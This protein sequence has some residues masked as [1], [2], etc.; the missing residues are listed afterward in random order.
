MTVPRGPLWDVPLF[1]LPINGLAT[2]EKIT[3]ANGHTVDYPFTGHWSV[4]VRGRNLGRR[5][6]L[7]TAQKAFLHQTGYRFRDYALLS[8]MY[9]EIG[10]VQLGP[11]SWLYCDDRHTWRVRLDIAAVSGTN[12]LHLKLVLV[13]VFGL[14][15]WDGTPPTMDEERILAEIVFPLKYRYIEARPTSLSCGVYPFLTHSEHGDVSAINLC[16]SL[17]DV[18][19]CDFQTPTFGYQFGGNGYQTHTV[20]VA[21]IAG[22]GS[23][24]AGYVGRG[25]TGSLEIL[26]Q[27]G[28]L[29]EAPTEGG[30]EGYLNWHVFCSTN[31]AGNLVWAEYASEWSTGYR[32]ASCSYGG[33]TLEATSTGSSV[34]ATIAHMVAPNAFIL[35]TGQA[36]TI[37]QR[38]LVSADGNSLASYLDSPGSSA[39]LVAYNPGTGEFAVADSSDDLVQWV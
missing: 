38:V 28:D 25:I 5:P 16:A 35:Q 27:G 29:V 12:R 23:V 14:L 22:T 8:G 33:V 37:A 4:L 7:N 17:D 36:G 26:K 3:L 30:A 15:E 11:Q 10:G 2:N 32:H 1:G 34:D 6:P 18:G 31:K 24:N 21:R 9:R 19:D 39:R 13:G 20:L